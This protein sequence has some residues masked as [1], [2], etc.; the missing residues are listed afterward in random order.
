M[1][2]LGYMNPSQFTKMTKDWI[3]FHQQDFSLTVSKDICVQPHILHLKIY[4]K[5]KLNLC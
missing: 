2:P 1:T 4:L 5:F 3:K